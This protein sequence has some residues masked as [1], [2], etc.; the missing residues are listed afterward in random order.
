MTR[1]TT[2]GALPSTANEMFCFAT[3]AASHAI[4]R[5]YKPFL[6]PLGLTYPQYITLTILWEEDGLAVG[7]L[8]RRLRMES[9]TVT[10]L[11]KRLQNLGHVERRRG[12]DDERQVFV[13]LTKTGKALQQHAPDITACMIEATGLD[14]SE[15]QGLVATL[16]RL[17]GS[18]ETGRP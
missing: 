1:K 6:A 18:L 15:L 10:P 5:A 3:Y 14:P 7:D 9:N 13:H 12:E 8:A 2:A 16:A 4:N 11:L 17:T